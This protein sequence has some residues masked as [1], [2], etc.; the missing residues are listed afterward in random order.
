MGDPGDRLEVRAAAGRNW[1][2]RKPSAGGR[3]RSRA[4]RALRPPVISTPADAEAAVGFPLRLMPGQDRGKC[5]YMGARP[6]LMASIRLMVI[7]E[8]RYSVPPNP[9]AVNQRRQLF[10]DSV[11]DGVLKDIPDV[12]DAALWD[13][14]NE[15]SGTGRLVAYRAGS[16]ELFVTIVGI[17]EDAALRGAERLATRALGAKT[18]YVY[19]AAP[20]PVKACDKAVAR[21]VCLPGWEESQTPH[22]F[23]SNLR[24]SECWHPGLIQDRRRL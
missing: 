10:H 22:L 15:N 2:A 9:G 12:S 4:A 3:S 20:A 19:A 17:S 6:G 13:W 21:N 16:T 11:T 5:F 24:W 18:G 8:V 14:T 23:R 1:D 7:V